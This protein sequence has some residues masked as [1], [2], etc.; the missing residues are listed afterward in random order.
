[1]SLSTLDRIENYARQRGL[2]VGRPNHS[3]AERRADLNVETVDE[4]R[5]RAT[6]L[7]QKVTTKT[8]K[9]ALVEIIIKAENAGLGS[10]DALTA[11]L[12]DRQRR[13]LRKSL[14]RGL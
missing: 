10:L 6:K 3:P 14:A 13:R 1:M 5:A 4:L 12:T 7:G 9:A 11:K 8:R 2:K